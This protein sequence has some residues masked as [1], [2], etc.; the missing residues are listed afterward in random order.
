M[1]IL[2]VEDEVKAA[3]F[4]QQG[5]NEQGCDVEIA[6]DGIDGQHLAM[7]REYDAIV[8]DVMLPGLDGLSLLRSLRTVR[9]TPVIMLTA[10][11]RVEDR[12]KGLQCGAD[13]YLVKPFAFLELLARLQALTRRGRAH[14]A[15]QL[16]VGDLQIDLL[17]HKVS[18]AGVRIDLTGKEFV[19][20]ELLARRQGEILSR[21][22]IAELVWDIKF[23]CETNVVETGI[24]RLRAKIDT[25]FEK[26]LLRTIRGMGYVLEDRG[27]G[28]GAR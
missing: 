28:A 14:E 17:K 10:R 11:D 13:D 4:L 8:L 12:I 23:D 1:K 25:P 5:L 22:A 26:H 21:T 6:H 19:L 16:N 7:H 3:V 20:L 15:M 24:K 9:Q 2:V 27:D 18:R